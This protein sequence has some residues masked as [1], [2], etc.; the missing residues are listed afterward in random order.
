M[1]VPIP[2]VQREEILTGQVE[3]QACAVVLS[4]VAPDEGN[5]SVLVSVSFVYIY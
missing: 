3:E 1:P 5:I 2:T 4:A